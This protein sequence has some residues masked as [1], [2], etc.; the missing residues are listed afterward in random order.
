MNLGSKIIINAAPT[1]LH[2]KSFIIL[3]WCLFTPDHKIEQILVFLFCAYLR[4]LRFCQ[5]VG[6]IRAVDLG[7]FALV[8]RFSRFFTVIFQVDTAL[9]TQLEGVEHRCRTVVE[10]VGPRRICLM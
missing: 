10:C 3:H 1:R 5:V 8:C 2:I 4:V 9:P 7:R 6:L